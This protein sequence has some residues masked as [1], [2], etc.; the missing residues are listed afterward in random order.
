[1]LVWATCPCVFLLEYTPWCSVTRTLSWRCVILLSNM[2]II[3][4]GSLECACSCRLTCL[5][6]CG[7]HIVCMCWIFCS[8][9]F[10]L[11]LWLVFIMIRK[12]FMFVKP[13][14]SWAFI[15]LFEFI[16]GTLCVAIIHKLA[17]RVQYWV[18]A[19]VFQ[20]VKTLALSF[21]LMM[22]YCYM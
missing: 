3:N 4:W 13:S 21:C 7:Q 15:L 6:R 9:F 5:L 19:Q 17:R 22:V 8:M 16:Y 18:F 10:L 12:G 2:N 20:L 1:M 11:G 14:D